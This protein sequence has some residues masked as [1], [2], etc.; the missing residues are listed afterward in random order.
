MKVEVEG[1]RNVGG[2]G[3][4]LRGGVFECLCNI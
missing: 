3:N 4:V 1:K 2:E